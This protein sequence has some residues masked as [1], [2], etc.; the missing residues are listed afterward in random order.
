MR[1]RMLV[2]VGLTLAMLMAAC[3][4]EDGQDEPPGDA[5]Q[6]DVELVGELSD[7]DAVEVARSVNEFG[8]D[9]QAALMTEEGG[10][11]VTSPLSVATLLAMVAVGAGGET[12][13]QMAE[14][15]YLDEVRDDRFATL[16]RTVSDTDDVVVSVANALWAN[17]GT[18]FEEDYLSFVQDVF[19]ATAEEAPLGEQA[20]ADEIDEWVVERTEGLIE[21][22]A[23]ELGLPDPEAVLVL[24]NAVYFLGDWSVSFDPELTSD[25]P[26]AL[27]DGSQVD[28][29]TMYRPSDPDRP[30]QVARRDGYEVL[31]LPYGDDGRF[32]MDVFLPSPDHDTAWLI[33]QLD[34]DERAAAT[35]ALAKETL[36]VRF[37]SFEL[38]TDEADVVLNDALIALGMDL[39]FSLADFSPM[40]P[41]NPSLSVVAHKTYIRVDEKGTEAAAVTGAKMTVSASLSFNV[42]RPFVFTVSDT[43][44]DTV[45]FLGTVEDP[46]D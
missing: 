26:F 39:P 46:R 38:E 4:T 35:E 32:V 44:T 45:L 17:G 8:F 20:T 15:L 25:Q 40:T 29:P 9:L 24:L 34:A 7:S 33:G 37:P 10:N 43:R 23:E 16:L 2:A 5:G 22:I 41:A 27:G 1:S 3:G 11:V 42:D 13:E 18:P 21:G 31:R 19:G 30:V 14:V 28:V 36:D 6:I 12:A